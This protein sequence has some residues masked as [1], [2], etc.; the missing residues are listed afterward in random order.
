MDAKLKHRAFRRLK[1]IGGQVRGLEKML[2]NGKYCVNIIHQSLAIK[3]ALS[4]FE[5]FILE[6][7]L[8]THAV[9]QIKS[10]QKR[11]AVKEI[12]SIYRLSGRK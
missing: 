9:R 7:H 8:S 4:S 2:Q 5:N 10:G 11:K 12:V 1:I 6:N 3:R